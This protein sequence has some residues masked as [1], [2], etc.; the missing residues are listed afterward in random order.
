MRFIASKGKV[1]EPNVPHHFAFRGADDVTYAVAGYL[2]AKAAKKAG[3]GTLVLQIMLNTPK[4]TGGLQDLAKARTLRALVRTLEDG[5][6]SVLLQPRG[7]LDYFSP[8]LD[9]AKAQ[10]ASVTALM[11]DIDGADTQSPAVIHVVSYS[12]AVRLADPPVINESIRITREALSEYRRMRRSGEVENIDDSPELAHRTQNLLAEARTVI[13]AIEESIPDPY[14]PAGFLKIFAAG[15][16]PVPRLWE[17]R[18]EFPEAV[19]WETRQVEGSI[20]VVG[21]DGIPVPAA[22]RMAFIRERMQGRQP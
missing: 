11:A 4:T 7:G 2:A 5:K 6:F 15:F 22:E 16:L 1:L 19:R 14:S 13:R 9:K 10:L 21:A 12:E 18:D 17:C 20:R 3:I 8:D